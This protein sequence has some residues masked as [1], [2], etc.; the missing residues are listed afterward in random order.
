MG[1]KYIEALSD[2]L[3]VM[4]QVTSVYQCFDESSNAYLD[5]C[6]EI[7]A[8]FDDFTVHHV[9]MDENIVVNDLAQQ[10]SGFQSNQGKFY[11]LEKLDVLGMKI[12]CQ[13]LFC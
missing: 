11:V 13:I 7:I 5:K 4:Q 2:S 3:L 6:L 1:V 12:Q 8:L 9:S 10:A